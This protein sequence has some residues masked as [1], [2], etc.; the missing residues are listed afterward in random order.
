LSTGHCIRNIMST[1]NPQAWIHLM[2][3]LHIE[4]FDIPIS[5]TIKGLCI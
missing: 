1:A 2:K 5:I 4:P 3:L